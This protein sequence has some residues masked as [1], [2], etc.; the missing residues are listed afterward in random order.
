MLVASGSYGGNVIS[1]LL[2]LFHVKLRAL[3]SGGYASWLITRKAI[4][5]LKQILQGS[6]QKCA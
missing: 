4:N 1:V 3:Y 2:F 6:E 5:N